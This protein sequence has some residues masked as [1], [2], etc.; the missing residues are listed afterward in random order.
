M[1]VSAGKVEPLAV[2]N[3]HMCETQRSTNGKP[4]KASDKRIHVGC[5][6]CDIAKALG[7]IVADSVAVAQQFAS[8]K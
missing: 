2:V 1:R 8:Q 3:M 4:K 6:A 5:N 7:T